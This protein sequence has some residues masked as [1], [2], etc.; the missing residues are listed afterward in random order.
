[1][2]GDHDLASRRAALL[3]AHEVLSEQHEELRDKGPA[4]LGHREHR[5]ALIEHRAA[6][7]QYTQELAPL[8]EPQCHRLDMARLNE[9]TEQ[10]LTETLAAIDR[11]RD[12]WR[13][14][15]DAWQRV[16]EK[17]GQNS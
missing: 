12:A 16:R 2:P 3:D 5:D 15:T 6:I 9:E 4:L 1:M 17:L 14:A 8:S 11:A 10:M 7:A 13:R